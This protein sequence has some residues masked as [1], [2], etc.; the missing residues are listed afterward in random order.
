MK[1]PFDTI[2]KTYNHIVRWRQLIQILIKYGFADVVDVLKLHHY[3]E[4]GKSV[5]S[6]KPV[7]EINSITREERIRK[8]VEEMGTTFIKFGQILSTRPDLISQPLIEE[9]KKLQDKVAPFPDDQAIK[10]I[11]E[12]LDG[13]TEKLFRDFSETPIASASIGQVYSGY[14]SSGEKVAIKVRRP[15]IEKIVKVDLEILTN[16]AKLGENHLNGLEIIQPVAIIEEF[17]RQ[18]DNE[19]NFLMEAYNIERFSKNA[20]K[21]KN[22]HSINVFRSHSTRIVLTTEFAE[23]TKIDCT[24]TLNKK[25]VDKSKIAVTVTNA[26]LKQIFE[27]GFFHGDPH[28]GNLLVTEDQKVCFLDFG[29]MGALSKKDQEN[30]ADLIINVATNNE[31][32]ITNSV[33]NVSINSD[34]I[35]DIY[36][37]NKEILRFVNS[38]AYLPINQLDAGKILQD[39]LNL[40]IKFGIRLPPEYYLLIK[41]LVTVEGIGNSL[42]P[43]FVFMDYVKPYAEK[44]VMRR[45][46]PRKISK[47][48]SKTSLE[49]YKL[50]NDMP[51]EIREIIKFV[52]RGEIKI[53]LETKSLL[54]VM[55]TWDKDA[56]RLAF[57]IV[58]A[59]ILLSSALIIMAKVPPMWQDVSVPGMIGFGLSGLMALRLLL[60]IMSSGHM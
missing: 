40:I 49:F 14:L 55:K 37:L 34:E 33:L 29:M 24:E 58:N 27:D 16:L 56:N 42:D 18:L 2:G 54:P 9:F 44:L 51:G 48:I 59:S 13:K 22:I 57:A 41:S 17:A 35:K 20:K 38:Y 10:I 28:P 19:M 11:E 25:G 53:D 50:A 47:D 46:D 23:G 7:K 15:D 5:V 12:E 8:V 26:I 1:T 21:A 32:E 30:F 43:D 52:K 4:V 36:K 60:A 3:I 31:D 45:Y 6:R 39:L